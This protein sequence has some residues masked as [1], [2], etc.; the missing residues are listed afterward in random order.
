MQ[1]VIHKVTNL[2]VSVCTCRCLGHCYPN[3]MKLTWK[4]FED[5]GVIAVDKG[6][7]EDHLPT[8]VMAGLKRIRAQHISRVFD[9]KETERVRI[10]AR[11]RYQARASRL[12]GGES[13]GSYCSGTLSGSGSIDLQWQQKNAALEEFDTRESNLQNGHLSLRQRNVEISP[14]QSVNV[15]VALEGDSSACDGEN[16]RYSGFRR[17]PHS[18]DGVLVVEVHPRTENVSEDNS[19]RHIQSADKG[20]DTVH[21]S[22]DNITRVTST[23]AAVMTT[24]TFVQSF[25]PRRSKAA[26]YAVTTSGP[27]PRDVALEMETLSPSPDVVLV[28][29]PPSSSDHRK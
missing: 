14:Q 9:P 25:A 5:F 22:P 8:G 13:L 19:H 18:Q 11:E 16:E 20:S 17:G 21:V 7:V 29:P 24:R 28:S 23:S 26:S 12:R 4:S 15:A 2:P 3:K 1:T 6:M 27:V 10:D